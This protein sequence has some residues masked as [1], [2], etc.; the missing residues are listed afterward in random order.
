MVTG[1]NQKNNANV[2]SACRKRRLKGTGRGEWESPLYKIPE[3]QHERGGDN[4]SSNS[5]CGVCSTI[6]SKRCEIGCMFGRRGMGILALC[7]MKMKG[8]EVAF[9]EV[10]DG[11]SGVE[12]GRVRGCGTIVE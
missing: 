8:K 6:E 4:F 1:N 5:S 9:G 12:R 3:R 11:V 10:T 2:F 7:E